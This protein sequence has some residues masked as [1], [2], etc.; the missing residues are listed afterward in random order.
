MRRNEPEEKLGQSVG[1]KNLETPDLGSWEG[2]WW[3]PNAGMDFVGGMKWGVRL[4][5]VQMTQLSRQLLLL[6]QSQ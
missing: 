2:E 6:F 3:G 4:R 1:S 5:Q